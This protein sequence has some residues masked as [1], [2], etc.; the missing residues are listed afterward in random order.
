MRMSKR[1]IVIISVVVVLAA[2]LSIGIYAV[3]CN[4]WRAYSVDISEG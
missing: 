4:A 2:A 1:L 3:S